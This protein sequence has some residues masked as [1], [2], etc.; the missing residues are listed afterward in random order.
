[1]KWIVMLVFMVF[2]LFIEA[3]T[4]LFDYSPATNKSDSA[5][6]YIKP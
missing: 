2:A 5:M 4:V 3:Q 6:N 1:M